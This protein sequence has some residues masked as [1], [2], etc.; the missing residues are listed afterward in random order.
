[1]LV[2]LSGPLWNLPLDYQKGQQLQLLQI[3][4]P[5]FL[6]YLA[7]AATYAISGQTFP[8]PEGER[9][10]ILRRIAAG[11]IALFLAGFVLATAVFFIS[12]SGRM[13]VEVIDFKTY[14]NLITLLVGLLS[15]TTTAV[16]SFVFA[17]QTG[18][19]SRRKKT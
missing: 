12:G 6:S 17:Q 3:A 10:A 16:A 11:G 8:E 9:G 13:A 14:S 1:M 18:Q 5:T 19:S 2:Y 7:S 15:V 4:A